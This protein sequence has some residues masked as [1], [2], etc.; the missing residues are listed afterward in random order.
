MSNYFEF[1]FGWMRNISF[2]Y[3]Y[4]FALLLL[5]LIPVLWWGSFR[6]L[7]S[8]GNG[9]RWAALTFRSLVLLLI[10]FALAGI[11]WVWI[12]N[13]VSVIYLLDQSDSIPR[14]KRDIM[15]E[16]AIENVAA[17]RNYERG[18]RSG[19][20]IFGREAAIEFP[21]YD[22]DLPHVA[23]VESYLGRTDATNLESALKLAQ[24]SF[25]EDA[26]KRIVIVTDGNETLGNATAL[27]QALSEAG[28]GI[29]IVPVSMSANSEILVEKVVLPTSMRQG[30]PFETRIVVNRFQESGDAPVD[31]RLRLLRS[32]GGRETLIFEDDVVLDKEVNVF[33]ITDTIEQPAGYTYRAEFLPLNREDDAIQQNNRADA[34]TYVRGKGRV[35]LIEDWNAP[36]EF[37]PLIEA[38]R[39]S[40][41][42]VDVLP[43]NQLF[44][45]LTELQVY[46]CVVLA[47]VP[48]SSGDSALDIA[49][50]TDEQLQMLVTNTQQFG[51]GL[52]ML[53]GPNA[54][55]AGGWANTIVE[56][57]MPVDFQIKNTKIE[58]VGALAMIL[59]ASEI[60]QGNY[61]QKRIG[62][63]ALEVLGP[64]DY[65]G[66]A[67]YSSLGD[68]WL[69][70]GAQ[71]MLRVGAN[72][73]AMV[74]RLRAMTPGDMP[75]FQ[76]AMQMALRSL[77]NTPASI[78]HM[79]II[80]D[81]D[82]TPP[83]PAILTQFA[84][85]QIKISTVA[86]GAHGPA[87]HNTLQDI[88]LKTGG[89]YYVAT[90]PS[91]LPKIFQREAMRVARP[92]VYEP[93]G[94]LMPRITYPH[95]IVQ[96]LSRDLPNL[97]GFVL[98]SI[99]DSP[100]VEV[101]I[102]ASNPT[103]PENQAVL[104]TWTYGLGRTA[105][106]SSDVGKRWAGAW[107]DWSGYDQLFAQLV[108]WAMRP[109]ESD[110]KFSIATNVTDGQVQV[111]VNALDQNDDF[112]NFL[113]MQAVAVGPDLKP[114]P[115][116]MRQVAPGRYIGSFDTD[117]SG[118]YL[119]NM[120]PG[121]GMA[122]V[123]TGASVPFSDEYRIKPTNLTML[124]GLAELEPQGGQPGHLSA[125]LDQQ[126]F[127]E[128]LKHDVYRPGLPRAMT[129]QDIW[130]WCLMFGAV[131]L[132][133]D[134]LVRRVSLDYAYPFKWWYR[135]LRPGVTQQDAVR[136]ASLARLRNTKTEVSDELG[137]ARAST[138]FES[139][140]PAEQDALEQAMGGK[141]SA[142]A[143]AAPG[144]ETTSSATNLAAEPQQAGYTSRLL[145]AK[146]A[147]QQ[148]KKHEEK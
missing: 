147:A 131:C 133:G 17:H 75:D 84:S 97:K 146:K 11:Q 130:P 76:P 18:D 46:D 52:I 92:L 124:Q 44:T 65:C 86:V 143:G 2:S 80:S 83:A 13:T 93:D 123:T 122:P 125:P 20:I 96:G 127:Q 63:A 40:E 110:A 50:F 9:R 64:M 55:G 126:S 56:E 30:Q 51:A 117:G 91:A 71:G 145:A 7:S 119:V 112:L 29:D 6:S 61:W 15:L 45:S 132:F 22:D 14:A 38:L 106:F 100:L 24:A 113:D 27:A 59:H 139:E 5:I 32:V 42:E 36:N 49:N 34:F 58:A 107:T 108:R 25:P 31:G 74:S 28:I 144:A 62:Q 23:G 88:S 79:I 103:E 1:A 82:P 57:A 116:T 66:V 72:R 99:K 53:G 135:K 137:S 77:S 41:I 111:V 21:P 26:A 4:P 95:E 12:S 90:N 118:S 37:V 115:L 102:R 141:A 148:K 78:K 10:V 43:S 140:S 35:L 94:G 136:Q 129:M 81:G 68:T 105:V 47:G 121:P 89:N 109:T 39:R 101:P 87:G 70:G 16:Y 98:T 33:P 120:L 104:A 69:W 67:V 3:E 60:A 138:R 54:L 114:L 142:Q 8:L 19:L 134:V 85:N 128:L 73:Q 48:R